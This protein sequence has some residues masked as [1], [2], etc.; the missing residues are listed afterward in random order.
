M[1]AVVGNT[2]IPLMPTDIRHARRLSKKRPGTY[3]Q[4]LSPVHH[5]TS[6]QED[7]GVPASGILPDICIS[8]FPPP[9]RSTNM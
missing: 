3:I 8:V 6:G 1:V 2:G 7:R 9:H 5:P 4:T